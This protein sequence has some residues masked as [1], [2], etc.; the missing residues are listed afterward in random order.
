MPLVLP[1]QP[2]CVTPSGPP[3]QKKICDNLLRLRTAVTTRSISAPNPRV[4]SSVD[5]EVRSI[6]GVLSLFVVST[7]QS[8]LH[9]PGADDETN[10][11]CN[12][13]AHV[14]EE[15]RGV[16]IKPEVWRVDASRITR[17]K[18]QLC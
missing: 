1:Y 4:S 13:E 3:T 12:D 6:R 2:H 11:T 9:E 17:L 7:N 15:S 10:R 5:I 18:N 14:R 16:G 8:L